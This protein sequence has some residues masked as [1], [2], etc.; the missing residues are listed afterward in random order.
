MDIGEPIR[1][2]G[3]VDMEP[4]AEAI[5]SGRTKDGETVKITVRDGG[6]VLNGEAVKVA[7]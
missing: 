1:C 5:L 7:A 6:L 4:L 3:K 2:F